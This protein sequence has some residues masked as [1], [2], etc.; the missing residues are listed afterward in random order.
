MKHWTT[1][2]Q[3]KGINNFY[4]LLNVK[5]PKILAGMTFNTITMLNSTGNGKMNPSAERGDRGS[6]KYWESASIL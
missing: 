1:N 5:T 4:D 6:S 2:N 3:Y